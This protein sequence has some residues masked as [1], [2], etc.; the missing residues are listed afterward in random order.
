MSPAIVN[1]LP[2]TSWQSLQHLL[3]G[4]VFYLKRINMVN[5]T[6][7]HPELPKVSIALFSKFMTTLG[8]YATQDFPDYYCS[9]MKTIKKICAP[10]VCR[11]E[12][13]VACVDICELAVYQLPLILLKVQPWQR[14]AQRR[15]Q[16]LPKKLSKQVVCP[17]RASYC[18]SCI[19]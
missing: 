12:A 15:L 7:P 2:F 17:G 9:H 6:F 3:Y 19:C 11:Y 4:N 5:T 13:T 10:K 14:G 16:H 18:H 1:L 8:R